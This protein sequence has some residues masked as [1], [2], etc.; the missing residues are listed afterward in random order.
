VQ[1]YK[2]SDCLGSQ[3]NINFEASGI[4][5]DDNKLYVCFDN[6]PAVAVLDRTLSV[7][8]NSS[9]RIIHLPQTLNEHRKKISPS[10]TPSSEG[11][12]PE[13]VEIGFEAISA[14]NNTFV[15][16][17][18]I[19][20]ETSTSLH[21]R[22]K[23]YTTPMFKTKLSDSLLHWQ[24]D[25]E[26]KGIE[27]VAIVNVESM[28]FLLALCEGNHCKA[29]D[30]G[31]DQGHGIILVYYLNSAS[32]AWMYNDQIHLPVPFTDF[33][34]MDVRARKEESVE[35]S[36]SETGAERRDRLVVGHIAVV[37]QESRGLF[38][39]QYVVRRDETKP[40]GFS[41][42]MS[43]MTSSSAALYTFPKEYCN[44]E[45]V[46]FLESGE[47]GVVSDKRKRS[48]DQEC[49]VKDQSVHLFHV[50]DTFVAFDDES[51]PEMLDRQS[52]E[53]G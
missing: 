14:F 7:C 52:Q 6:M 29:G 41:F 25:S 34:G 5:S 3:Q 13:H 46:T 35:M 10:A 37:S 4:I 12:Q 50:S 53:L 39:G 17:Q 21:A 1:E 9:A 45:G 22:V 51:M 47:I 23:T 24:F 32:S 20:A 27:G 44:I 40:S 38:L 33:S 28:F 49:S 19:D 8:A 2:I 11:R 16:V 31:R 36:E 15:V 26:N 48:Q 18:E 43:E 42:N 30:E